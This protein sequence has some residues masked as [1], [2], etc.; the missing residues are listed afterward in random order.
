[1]KWLPKVSR[2]GT[3]KNPTLW[4]SYIIPFKFCVS[5]RLL[6]YITF[7]LKT[8]HW[9]QYAKSCKKQNTF[10]RGDK[11]CYQ[12]MFHQYKWASKFFPLAFFLFPFLSSFFPSFPPSLLSS[13]ILSSFQNLL[14]RKYVSHN[15]NWRGRQ[16]RRWKI[17]SENKEG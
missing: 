14:F 1:M 2:L 15:W 8:S 7:E 10:F 4:L 17:Q 16:R 6:E 12:K 13:F 5:D 3:P 11:N 9:V